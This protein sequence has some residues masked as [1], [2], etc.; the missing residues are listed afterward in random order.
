MSVMFVLAGSACLVA[1]CGSRT[2]AGKAADGTK[3][4]E[5]TLHVQDMSS[6]LG[7]T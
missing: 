3:L 7:L 5:A 2:G 1:G 6:R 4:S